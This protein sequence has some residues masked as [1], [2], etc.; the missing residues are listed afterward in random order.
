MV[1]FLYT[2]D[3]FILVSCKTSIV[4]CRVLGNKGLVKGVRECRPRRFFSPYLPLLCLFCLLCFVG[5]KNKKMTIDLIWWCFAC[6]FYFLDRRE[7]WLFCVSLARGQLFVL[8]SMMYWLAKTRIGDL[9][10]TTARG[11]ERPGPF[12]SLLYLF[13]SGTARFDPVMEQT[14][15]MWM[16]AEVQAI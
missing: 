13:F 5:A 9:Q 7:G 11:R 3:T 4:R 16:D 10:Y 12:S 2:I 6:V 15:E 1:S 8:L 14:V